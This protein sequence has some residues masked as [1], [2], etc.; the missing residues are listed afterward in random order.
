MPHQRPL[1]LSTLLV[2]HQ[3]PLLV[4]AV[5]VP[6]LFV[7]YFFILFKGINIDKIGR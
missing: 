3:R 6:L 4:D 5:D 1:S 7:F 2:H